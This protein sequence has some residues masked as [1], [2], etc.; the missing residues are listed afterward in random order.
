M[1]GASG[2]RWYVGA[3]GTGKTTRALADAAALVAET[4][5]PLVVLDSAGAAQLETV[6]H[7]EQLE[8]LAERVWGKGL[9]TAWIGTDSEAVERLLAGVFAG[10]NCILL[11]DETAFWLTSRRGT[12][13]WLLRLMR[14]HRH[15]RVWLL[16]TTQ[17]F[18]GDLPQ[19]ALACGPEL[20]VSR[21][22]SPTALDLLERR[23]GCDPDMIRRLPVGKFLRVD[24]ESDASAGEPLER[25]GGPAAAEGAFS[26]SAPDA[27][28][29]PP[30]LS[31]SES[32][33]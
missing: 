9:H 12:S 19:E 15:A 17:H 2:V 20:L 23:Y 26:P 27:S 13:S 28:A 18:S 10:G 16:L 4:G 5:Y 22:T 8:Q 1:S 25:M 14:S 3:P 33:T 32:S 31:Q 7:V 11:V 24:L 21:V 30:D 6:P 29:G